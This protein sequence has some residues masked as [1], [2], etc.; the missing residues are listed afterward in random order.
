MSNMYKFNGHEDL[1][2]TELFLFIAMQETSEQ[3]GI[4]DVEYLILIFSGFN[5][6]PTRAKPLGATKGTSVASVMSRA[7]FKYQFRRKILPT[8]TLESMKA[9]RWVLTHKLSVFIGRALP[10]VGWVLM[11]RDVGLIGYQTVIK[12]NRLVKPE[13]RVF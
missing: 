12:F 6:L 4:D 2:A 9:A 11:A 5:I 3:L 7:V 10:G 13:D 8:F 1:S